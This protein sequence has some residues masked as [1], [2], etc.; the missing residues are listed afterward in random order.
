MIL[1]KPKTKLFRWRNSTWTFFLAFSTDYVA[2]AVVV[3]VVEDIVSVA[4]ADLGCNYCTVVVVV[5]PHFDVAAV[6]VADSVAVGFV[7]L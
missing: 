2:A 6:V 3:V 1:T 5:F 7:D 4:V